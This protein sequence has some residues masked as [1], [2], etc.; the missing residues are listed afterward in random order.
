MCEGL[1]KKKPATNLFVEFDPGEVAFGVSVLETEEPDL[2][3]ADGLDDLV[4]QLFASRRLLDRELQLRVHR[5]HTDVHLEIEGQ[6][7]Y[8]RKMVKMIWSFQILDV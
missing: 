4:K 5:R 1:C 6:L 7:I 2:S 8:D 3:Q